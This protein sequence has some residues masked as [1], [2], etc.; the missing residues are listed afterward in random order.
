MVTIFNIIYKPSKKIIKSSNILYIYDFGNL[1]GFLINDDFKLYKI[2]HKEMKKSL[3][4]EKCEFVETNIPLYTFSIDK[5]ECIEENNIL[6]INN[7]SI[8]FTQDLE[9]PLVSSLLDEQ[10][11][12]SDCKMSSSHQ[13]V[14]NQK[15]QQ[16]QEQYPPLVEQGL[17]DQSLLKQLH[18]NSKKDDQA[19]KI[20][21][22]QK[23]LL[24]QNLSS[25]MIPLSQLTV[26]QEQ[27]QKQK[28][29]G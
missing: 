28:Q 1:K 13:Q 5:Y 11:V 27:Q 7:Y 2:L 12:S 16:S 23:P 6:Y 18:K 3:L 25:R 9:E 20:L 22:I 21:E 4:Y 10:K 29:K 15:K 17:F 8:E 14:H 26:R 19:K 24:L